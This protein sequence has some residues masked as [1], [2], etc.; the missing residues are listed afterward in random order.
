MIYWNEEFAFGSQSKLSKSF[1]VKIRLKNGYYTV[2]IRHAWATAHHVLSTF[3][4]VQKPQTL[5]PEDREE[6]LGTP[7]DETSLML[8]YTLIL[9]VRLEVKLLRRMHEVRI[10]C[11]ASNCHLH[12]LDERPRNRLLLPT[13]NMPSERRCS[14]PS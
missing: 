3:F 12:L 13:R 14:R 4:I 8:H 9:A 5:K 2:A 10:T 1:D 7:D 11:P 6:L